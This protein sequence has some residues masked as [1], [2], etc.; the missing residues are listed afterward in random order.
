MRKLPMHLQV[1]ANFGTKPLG[2]I[3]PLR[4]GTVRPGVFAV[5][6]LITNSNFVGC[7]IGKSAG[8]VP[9]SIRPA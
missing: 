8:L 4:N 5:L 7:V 9:L 3:E 6:R 2:S 1:C